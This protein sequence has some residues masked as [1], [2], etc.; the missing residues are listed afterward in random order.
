MKILIISDSHGHWRNVEKVEK[1]EKP[2]RVFFLGDGAED[3]QVLQS[4]CTGVLGN[5]DFSSRL[6]NDQELVE[7]CGKR[8]LLTHG[9]F[10][11]VKRGIGEIVAYALRSE[12]DIVCH[13]HSHIPALEVR[14]G[15]TDFNP[16]SL[17]EGEYGVLD[18]S[19]KGLKFTHK[20]I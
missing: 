5:C 15:V 4:E 20:K 8:F 17:W 1:K 7:I 16:G 18:I 13:G 10:Y 9:H 2:D 11:G 6:F 3:T 12:I 14:D 19:E